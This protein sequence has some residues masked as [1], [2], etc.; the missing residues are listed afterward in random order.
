M[1]VLMLGNS[2]TTRNGMP[3]RLAELLGREVAVH[4]RG[5]ARLA[6]QANPATR[7]GGATAAALA[8]GGVDAL[9]LQE[10]SH[11]PVTATGR[12]LES[13]A[14]LAAMAR[15]AGA[16]P[17][18]YGTWAFGAGSAA[19][20][21]LDLSPA[22]MH[23]AMQAALGRAE[24]ECG[25]AVANVGAAFWEAGDGSAVGAGLLAADGVHPSEAGSELAA[26]VLAGALGERG[27]AGSDA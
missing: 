23:G 13:V 6:E 16:V 17:V 9:V 11:G 15:E 5:G 10:M 24:R 26:R 8:A 3:D 19:L 20:G 7:L 22:E 14:R 18:V 2:L 27:G 1:A 4:A 21:R 12:F 25:V